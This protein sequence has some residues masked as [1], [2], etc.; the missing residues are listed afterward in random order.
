MKK[1]VIPPLKTQGIKTKIVPQIH[2]II[3]EYKIC[4]M[5]YEPFMGSGVVGFNL[6]PK[7]AVFSDSNPHII[8]FYNAIKQGIITKNSTRD[9]LLDSGEKLK[10]KGVDYYREIRQRFNEKGSPFDF[11]FLNR[12]CF[13]GLM[14]FNGSG[15]FNVP[16]CK[17]DNRFATAYITK[18]V[19]QIDF[20]ARII[21]DSD[22]LFVQSD[23]R[24]VLAKTREDDFIYLDPP[25]I[26]RHSDYYNVWKEE[27]EE[28]LFNFLKHTQSRFILS[29]WDSN[30]YRENPYAQK[31]WKTFN[32]IPIIHFYHVGAHEENRKEITEL[33]VSNAKL[34]KTTKRKGNCITPSLFDI[35]IL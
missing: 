17:K 14:R 30:S 15:E 20:V 18:I 6:R 12:S 28:F 4:G 7:Q 16:Y 8:N 27:D 19:N 21:K 31:W 25:Y 10:N 23:Y 5:Y 3:K 29:T 34:Q 35:D 22:Y 32:Y 24:D 33:L 1:I 26:G 2:E 13:N 9:F 11:L